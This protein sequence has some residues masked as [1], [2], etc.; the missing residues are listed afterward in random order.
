MTEQDLPK[1]IGP[2]KIESLFQVRRMSSIYLG[3]H[4]ETKRTHYY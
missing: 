1:T 2:Y 3:T 4:P